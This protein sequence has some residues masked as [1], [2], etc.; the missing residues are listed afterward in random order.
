MFFE[1][2]ILDEFIS[3]SNEHL[4]HIENYL[5][6]FE[7]ASEE[8]SKELIKEIFRAIHSIKGAAGFMG[9]E[10][11]NELAHT[12]ETLLSMLRSG[13]LNVSTS[14]IN[15]LLTCVDLLRVMLQDLSASDGVDIK[16]ALHQLNQFINLEGTEVIEE[17]ASCEISVSFANMT[18]N[19]HPKQKLM[20][21]LRDR[22]SYLY[23]IKLDLK[24][25]EK[26][27]ISPLKLIHELSQTGEISEGELALEPHNLME[28][29]PTGGLF[30]IF[31]YASILE[32]TLIGSV[33]G[34][35]SAEVMPLEFLS[36]GQELMNNP[37]TKDKE[38]LKTEGMM[39]TTTEQL[40]TTNVSSESSE[41]QGTT[42]TSAIQKE[43]TEP[44]RQ[45]T[46][47]N[48]E[49]STVR[50][51]VDVIEELMRLAGELVLV[52][53]QQLQLDEASS[54]ILRGTTQRLDIVTTEL[55][56]TIMKTRMQPI[57]NIFNKFN[58]V[59]RDISQKL[60][61][62]INLEINGADVELDKTIIEAL[63]DPLT[64]M[65]RNS[66]DHGIEMPEERIN[67]QKTE[68]GTISL[69]AYHEAGHIIVKI[70]DDGR[71]ID[72]ERIKL[73]AL[74]QKIISSAEAEQMS[75]R[76]L[77]MLIFHPGFS[78]TTEVSD[79]SGRGVGMDVV[80]TAIEKLGGKLTLQS[81]VGD[82]TEIT[83]RLPLTLA[84]IPCLIIM[85]GDERFA[86]PQVN[87]E[88][89][90]CLY[91][92]QALKEI[93]VT[94]GYEVFRLRNRLL[95]LVRLNKLLQ[96]KEPLKKYDI[97]KLANDQQRL[98]DEILQESISSGTKH[99]DST[100]FAVI[101]SGHSRYGLIID[102]V[103]G[104]EEVVVKP[105]H[106][107]LKD[108]QCYAGATVMGDGKVALIL[109]L[110]GIARHGGVA[111]FSLTDEDHEAGKMNGQEQETQ[112]VMLFSSGPNERFAL[113]LPL[114]KR[115]EKI[116]KSDIEVVGSRR[117]V[118]VDHVSTQVLCLDQAL[119]VSP[120]IEQEE[121]FLILPKHIQRP[122]GIL[123]SNLN[124]ITNVPLDLR[125]DSFMEDGLL[126]TQIIDDHLT[127]F[128]DIYRLI[129]KIE[130]EWFKEARPEIRQNHDY[131]ILMLEDAKFFQQMV[132]KYLESDN[133]Q[134]VVADDGAMGLELFNEQKFDLVVSDL[135]MPVMN[136]F[137]FIKELRKVNTDIPALA[138]SSLSSD[139]DMTRAIK[140]GFNRYN[141]KIDR[142]KLLQTVHELLNKQP[143]E[144]TCV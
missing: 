48:S 26:S 54:H 141:I 99:K 107:A 123:V 100:F 36:A 124:D 15:T 134:V 78:T 16:P 41:T 56:E 58:R 20:S 66:C 68:T 114:I 82:G 9:Y 22:Y 38:D 111:S 140:N 44:S 8:E 40:H 32:E 120:V 53:N 96:S 51:K 127:L 50:I 83:L 118:T 119:S 57:G 59:V 47:T 67:Q 89:M 24:K 6:N 135:E 5:I 143:M 139:E 85:V 103:L 105:M 64:H 72:A 137:E 42:S 113:A 12:M 3:E 133:Y 33:E 126:G 128:P 30:F 69:S 101:R 86:I 144:A 108:L 129:E 18:H 90:V 62:H 122:F 79:L 7:Q 34:L 55:Q 73:K 21:D 117:F 93:E 28:N 138:L 1:Q 106:T 109:N 142:E 84:I 29:L 130:P 19:Y 4:E 35:K 97:A 46:K 52:R 81:Q 76:D 27:G 17:S 2:E 125:N 121:M 92:E 132:R 116:N 98:R 45:V 13:E 31:L 74:S 63:T 88:E 80:K 102:K 43:A 49:N 136:G 25:L 14:Q 115:I 112:S 39:H 61:K 11:M 23:A 87:L 110:E 77:Q 95:P 60:N 104:T 10:T 94:E 65:I 91:D 131:R 70:K 71:G 75:K 37:P